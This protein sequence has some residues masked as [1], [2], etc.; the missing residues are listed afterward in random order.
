MQE[1]STILA[2]MTTSITDN[3]KTSSTYLNKYIIGLIVGILLL[4]PS[5]YIARKHQ[6][7]GLS[8]QIFY[9]F[10]NLPDLFKIPSLIVTEALGAAYPIILCIAI[11]AFYKRFR[12]AWLFFVTVGGTGVVMT[13]FKLI[14]KEPRP[15]ELLNGHL[16]ARAIEV[17]L[18]S[19]PSG[20]AAVATA[21]ALTLLL[22]LPKAYRWV[23][24]LWIVVVGVSRIYLGVHTLTDVIGGFA[25]GLIVFC[26]IQLLPKVIAKPLHLDKD[27]PLLE[28]GF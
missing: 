15:A 3:T 13:F 19:F 23:A 17:G 28:R 5:L 14:A 2:I 22:I 12:L 16:H 8:A 24:V 4:V 11:P 27:K 25:I 9:F 20:H 7:T 26:I 10:N 18:N 1:E 6:L 21:M